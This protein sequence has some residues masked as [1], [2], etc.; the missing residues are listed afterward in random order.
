M[1]VRIGHLSFDVLPLPPEMAEENEAWGLIDWTKG[2]IFVDPTR[3]PAAQAGLLLHEI[4]HGLW[5]FHDNPVKLTEEQVC[6][7]VERG[8]STVLQD[9]PWLFAT[10]HQA[11]SQGRPIFAAGAA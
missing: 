6:R 11:L 3:P 2:A 8:L 4:M 10:L 1:K 9:N 7:F 5:E